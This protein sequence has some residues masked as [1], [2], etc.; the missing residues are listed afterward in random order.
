[1]LKNII[2]ILK[3]DASLS[4]LEAITGEYGRDIPFL[5]Y[6]YTPLTND[7]VKGQTR[8]ELTAVAGSIGESLEIMENVNK[9][10]I[11]IGDKELTGDIKSVRQNGG[12]QLFNADTKTW[13]TKKTYTILYRERG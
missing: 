5:R 6:E 9:V 4:S 10:L 7:G 11:T 1:M 12:G 13:H 3:A 2:D 8:L